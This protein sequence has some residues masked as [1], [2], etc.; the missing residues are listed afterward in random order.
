MRR[1][2]F[3]IAAA[4]LATAAAT[5]STQASADPVAGAIVGGGI[6]AVVGGPP[7]RPWVP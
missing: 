3:W 6:G 1:K 7:A 5:F 2:T 4:G